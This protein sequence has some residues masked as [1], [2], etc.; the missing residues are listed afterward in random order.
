MS[1]SKCNRNNPTVWP[2][3][4][5]FQQQQTHLQIFNFNSSNSTNKTRTHQVKHPCINW[6]TL[7]TTRWDPDSM[8]QKQRYSQVL[9][10][11]FSI[12]QSDTRSTQYTELIQQSK[13]QTCLK[14]TS[15]KATQKGSHNRHLHRLKHLH[16]DL[17][18]TKWL[19]TNTPT[20]ELT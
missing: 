4:F 10:C 1:V 9:S 15:Q 3:W 7:P 18:E 12:I 19:S 5:N 14:Y 2:K 20:I 8:N 17:K 6:A 11:K 13:S 16:H